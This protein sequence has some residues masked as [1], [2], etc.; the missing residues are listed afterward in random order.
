MARTWN[1][2]H[3]WPGTYILLIKVP[4]LT[5]VI[6]LCLRNDDFCLVSLYYLTNYEDKYIHVLPVS[7]FFYY[8]NGMFILF[9]HYYT[10]VDVFESYIEK[11]SCVS[12]IW[13]LKFPDLCTE[14][15]MAKKTLVRVTHVWNKCLCFR[16]HKWCY[17]PFFA[18]INF[19]HLIRN[20]VHA[21][22]SRKFKPEV[23]WMSL[24]IYFWGIFKNFKMNYS[25]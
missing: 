13:A 23:P 2:K 20:L 8:S 6:F 11:Q 24:L 10:I 15:S 25:R 21:Q 7:N 3:R 9:L 12:T 1:R 4:C 22:R 16:I 17:I 5:R 19:L 14:L 18:D